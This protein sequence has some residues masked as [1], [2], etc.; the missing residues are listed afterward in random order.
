MADKYDNSGII[1]KNDRKTE[2]KHP[3]LNG[4]ATIGGVEYWLSGWRK[5]KNGRGFYTLSFKPKEASQSTSKAS[6]ASADIDDD[7][8]F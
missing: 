3:D 6:S 4:S 1:G 5:E 2:D 8:P 7:I